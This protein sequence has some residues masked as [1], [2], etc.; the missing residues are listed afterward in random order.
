[1]SLE[2]LRAQIERW[3]GI[4]LDRGRRV[5]MFEAAVNERLRAL[6]L[7][8]IQDYCERLKNPDD[9]EVERLLNAVTVT[10]TWFYRDPSQMAA[11]QS[12]FA[13]HWPSGQALNVWVAACATGEEAY[14]V[15]MLAA[16]AERKVNVL[17][18]DINSEALAHAQQGW[19]GKWSVRDLPATMSHLLRQVGERFEVSPAL[20]GSVR[21]QRHSLM[22]PAPQSP[23]GRG[24]D[25]IICRN[26]L[27][28]FPQKVAALTL[29]RLDGALHEKGWLLLGGSEV[30][31]EAP[32]AMTLVS[33]GGG[34]A[35]RRRS[36]VGDANGHKTP[37]PNRRPV[38][39]ASA[40]SANGRVSSRPPLPPPSGSRPPAAPALRSLEDV[41]TKELANARMCLEAGRLT[42]A[43]ASLT[44]VIEADPLSAR[45][46]MLL[47]IALHRVKDAQGAVRALRGALVLD[48]MLW[49]AAFYLALSYSDLGR[50]ND[51]RSTYAWLHELLARA[52]PGGEQD[53]V[54]QDF[55][56]WRDEVSVLAS[57]RSGAKSA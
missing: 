14:T 26:V 53:E 16:C 50:V 11:L 47:G 51:A 41:T 52:A 44:R 8:S 39:A 19:Y 23:S 5:D 4:A 42:E 36:A 32:P 28:Y 49:P 54:L 40:P 3:A 45:A 37:E 31:I 20:R 9:P 22:D 17:A 46:Q 56:P 2:L 29:Q 15:A 6:G 1:M 13:S 38:T 35:L 55:E 25:V 33:L 10:Y 34:K 18:T 21:F 57:M 43:I 24:W 27:I 7:G 30:V 48:A 12:L